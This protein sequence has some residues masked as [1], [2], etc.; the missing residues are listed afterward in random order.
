MGLP[1][2]VS[3]CASVKFARMGHDHTSVKNLRFTFFLNLGFTIIEFIGGF[4]TNSVAIMSDALHDL[5]DSISLGSAW[6]LQ[7]LSKKKRDANFSYGYGRF[8]LLGA[9][10]NA[11]VL[12]IGS[13]F[14]AFEAIPRLIDPQEVDAKGMMWFALFGIAVNGYAA[15]KLHRGT[16]LNE[17]VMGLHLLE[18]VLGWTAILISS[19]IMLFADLP[20]LD[21]ILSLMIMLFVLYNATKNMLKAM[22]V[23]LQGT[24]KD[25]DLEKITAAVKGLPNVQDVYHPHVW[26][27]DGAVNILT[28][29]VQLKNVDM[30]QAQV[31][32]DQVRVLLADL[33]I[34]H[35][36]IE[37]ELVGEKM[38]ISEY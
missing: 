20:I 35:A 27:L 12:I 15:W 4:L 29:H 5:G 8:S 3:R 25:V 9:W 28:L 6:Y 18:D 36:T 11:T 23:F 7:N 2:A 26:S 22:K 32:K 31:I 10:I 30:A 19:I 14:I 13:L 34:Q 38:D 17:Q 16:S 33:N 1:D 21:P 37:T 24:P